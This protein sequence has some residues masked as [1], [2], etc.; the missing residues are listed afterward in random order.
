MTISG[1]ADLQQLLSFFES[2]LR[3]N[4]FVFEGELRIVDREEEFFD[5]RDYWK[6]KFFNLLNAPD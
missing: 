5:S 1:E 3:A 2:F 6:G 4:G